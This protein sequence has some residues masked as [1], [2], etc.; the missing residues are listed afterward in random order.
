MGDITPKC[1]VVANY[2][3]EEINKFNEGKSLREQVLM[4]GRRL[5][6]ILY[7]SNIEYMKIHNGK[8]LFEDCFYAWPS[9]PVIPN[10][11]RIY[12]QYQD[13]QNFPRYEGEQLELTNE[14]KCIINKVLK[15]TEELDTIDLI[16]I[17]NIN[18][19][20]WQRFYD[21]NDPDHNQIIPKEEIYNYYLNKEITNK[22]QEERVSTL[23]KKRI[24]PKNNPNK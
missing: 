12:I 5:Q 20:P 17:T 13:G 16:N 2:I 4:S 9:G 10:V 7:F 18:G 6:K 24:P 8:P 3:I 14:E 19:S 11:Y 21:E 22:T 1:R 23:T 15:Q